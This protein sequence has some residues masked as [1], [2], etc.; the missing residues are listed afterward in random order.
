M[1]E[2]SLYQSSIHLENTSSKK[3]HPMIRKSTTSSYL[4]HHPT[5]RINYG[6]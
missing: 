5:P 3:S 4:F 6:K 1:S 2:D